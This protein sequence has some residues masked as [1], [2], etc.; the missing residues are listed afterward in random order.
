MRAGSKPWAG[1]EFKARIEK[2]SR[3][4][5]YGVVIGLLP[6]AF[7][8]IKATVVGPHVTLVML[9]GR[10]DLFLVTATLVGASFGDLIAGGR[11]RVLGKIWVGFFCFTDF[12]LCLIW[13][14]AVSEALDFH[15]RYDAALTATVSLAAFGLAVALCACA[16]LLSEETKAERTDGKA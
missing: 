7:P 4:L 16:L 2:L 6:F 8:F 12:I 15:Q 13:F 5:L 14:G 10:G 1:A 11:E 3:W 9:F